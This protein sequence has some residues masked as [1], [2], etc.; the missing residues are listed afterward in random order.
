MNRSGAVR[1]RAQIRRMAR[2]PVMLTALAVV[3]WNELRLPEQR[4]YLYDSIITWLSRSREQR[5]GRA[6]GRT[7]RWSCCRSWPWRCKPHRSPKC[8]RAGHR[9]R[10]A[11][12]WATATRNASEWARFRLPPDPSPQTLGSRTN[13]RQVLEIAGEA[14]AVTPE[15]IARAER[16]L[17]QEEVDSGIIVGRGKEVTFWHLTFQEFLAAI[18]LGSCRRSGRTDPADDRP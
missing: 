11:S 15:S 14:A 9:A 13:R 10:S 4:A 6:T 7:E 2:N 1:V 3:H 17:D 18:A 16:F 8:Q 5:P 12:E